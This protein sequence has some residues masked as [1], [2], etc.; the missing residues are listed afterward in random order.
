MG[1]KLQM[2]QLSQLTVSEFRQ[3][4]SLLYVEPSFG[5]KDIVPIEVWRLTTW[6][7][8]TMAARG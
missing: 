4:H 5:A 2:E 3:A 1:T 8:M 7:S 6:T